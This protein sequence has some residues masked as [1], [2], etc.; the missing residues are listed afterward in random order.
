[1][2][3]WQLHPEEMYILEGD[4][5]VLE[6]MRQLRIPNLFA[7]AS[8]YDEL[9][10]FAAFDNHPTHWIVL[11]LWKGISAYSPNHMINRLVRKPDPNGLVFQAI[12]KSS[13]SRAK[14]EIQLMAEAREMESTQPFAFQQLPS[15]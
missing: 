2:N 13:T 9:H 10:A 11:H 12:P 6:L 5:L 7:R 1:M 14:M 8:E 15:E 4:A 3:V